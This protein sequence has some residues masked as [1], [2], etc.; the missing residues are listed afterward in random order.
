MTTARQNVVKED[1]VTPADPFDF[2]AGHVDPN[3]AID[4]GLVYDSGLF[5]YLA[6]S[7]ETVTPLVSADGCSFL[8]SLGFSLDPADLNLPSIGISQL[9]GAK[10]IK[11]TVTYVGKRGSTVFEA[12]V[13]APAGFRVEVSPRKLFLRRGDTATFEVTITNETAPPGEWRFGSLTWNEQGKK[14]VTVRS[15]I[16]VNAQAIVAPE[17]VSGTGADGGLQFDVTFGYTGAYTA[18]V[19]GLADSGLTLVRVA[20]DPGNSFQFLGPGT[21]IAF[22]DE[23]PPGTAFARWSLFDEYTSGLG[24]DDL[25]LYLYYCP[26]FLCTLVDSSGNLGSN[27]EVSVTLPLNDPGIDDPYVVFVHGYETAGRAPST[28][29][30][31]DW[32][33]GLVDNRGNMTVTA[34]N[35]ATIGQTETLSVNWSGLATGP[36]E[37]QL[38]A[39]SHSD[40]GGLR[41]LTLIDIEND[42]GF[43]ICDFGLC[44]AP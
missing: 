5:D 15:P 39:I 8:Q 36:G 43:T 28:L 11:R 44:A 9:P 31:F 13:E 1:G 24:N 42:Q 29:V 32:D 17:E 35:A 6:G 26:E 25:D 20:D 23:V 22:L 7:C 27:E 16:A 14:G 3:K 40:A 4:P 34:P 18:G 12:K 41:G 10:T 19:H 38:G 30:L 21:A 33:F 2:G 37:K